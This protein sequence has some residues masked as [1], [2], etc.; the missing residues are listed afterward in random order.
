MVSL[1]FQ[2]LPLA[3]AESYVGEKGKSMKA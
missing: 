1:S 3:A 2:A